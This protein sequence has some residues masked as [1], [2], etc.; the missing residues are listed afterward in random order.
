MPAKKLP[1]EFLS[2]HGHVVPKYTRGQMFVRKRKHLLLKKLQEGKAKNPAKVEKKPKVV[3]QKR[4]FTYKT[5]AGVEK[6]VTVNPK[7]ARISTTP[8]VKKVRNTRNTTKPTKLRK[9]L[10]PGTVLILLSGRFAGRRVVFLKQLE[11]GLLLVTGPFKLNG[12]PLRRVNQ[13]YVIATSTKVDLS[14]VNA[15]VT[16]KHFQKPKVEKKKEEP[17]TEGLF[18][19]KENQKTPLPEEF[20]QLQQS[21]DEPILAAVKK[22][23]HLEGYLKTSFSLKK[24]QYPHELKF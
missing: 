21:V 16:D 15:S 20:K 17:K 3:P 5:K 24:G 8:T 6:K 23:E 1:Q 10:T 2:S 22:V 12:V 14:G 18:A 7:V 19:K 11:S 13:R 4:T 9:S